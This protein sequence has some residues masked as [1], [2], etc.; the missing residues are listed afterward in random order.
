MQHCQAGV[1][2]DISIRCAGMADCSGKVR[3]RA[4]IVVG[5]GRSCNVYA[6]L[7]YYNFI[8]PAL[9]VMNGSSVQEHVFCLMGSCPLQVVFWRKP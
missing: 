9:S 4:L 5:A 2:L 6:I 3:L 1:Q 7:H 8:P